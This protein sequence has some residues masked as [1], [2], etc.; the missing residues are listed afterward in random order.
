MDFHPATLNLKSKGKWVTTYIE[1]PEGY[2]ASNINVCTM[3]L[4][5]QVQAEVHSTEI[6]DYDNDDIADIMVK[7]D[8]PAV[9]EILEVGDE[10]EIAVTG[11]LTD[12]T[13]FGGTDTIRV[14]EKGK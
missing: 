14:I 4:N 10:I 9:Q 8:R 1:L 5:D 2:D 3:M 12:G 13:S 7:F 6:G 11:E